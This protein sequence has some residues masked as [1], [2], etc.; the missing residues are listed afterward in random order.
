MLLIRT[1]PAEHAVSQFAVLP[2]P[3]QAQTLDEVA[4]CLR[5]LKTW[6]GNPSYETITARVNTRRPPGEQVGKTTVVDCFRAGRRRIDPD[7]V[8]A[9]VEALHADAGYTNQWRQAL[10]VAT[11]ETRGA[12][13]QVRVLGSL[14]GLPVGFVGRTPLIEPAPLTVLSGMAGAGKTTLA[15]HVA[16]RLAATQR[17]DRVLAVNLRGSHADQPPAGPEAVLDGFLRLLGVAGQHLPHGL[18][19]Q[20]TAYR[21]RLSGTRTLVLLDDAADDSQVR[22]LTAPGAGSVTLV[23]SRRD[24]GGLTEADHHTVDVLSPAEAREFLLAAVPPGADPA[25]ADRIAETCGYL[26]LA[27][28]RV[29]AHMRERPGWTPADHADWL[30]ERR[31]SGRLDPLVR[32]ALDVSYRNLPGRGRELLRLLAHHP[33]ASF[34]APAAAALAGAA[35]DEALRDLAA[36]HLLVPAG[37]ARWAMHDLVRV[38]AAGRSADEDRRSDR[39]AALTRLFDHLLTTGADEADLAAAADYAAA[40]GWPFPSRQSAK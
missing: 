6:A 33:G 30:A 16:H 29:V 4:A 27:L 22:P 18:A 32:Q 20:S 36:H 5:L 19:A 10:R 11:G 2:D 21:N 8:V 28:A 25:A 24:L 38:Y 14:P 15:L 34:D 3:G 17:F 26:P 12:G 23:T 13:D 40:E 1:T 39:R 7:L 9:V 35:A 37:G 31:R